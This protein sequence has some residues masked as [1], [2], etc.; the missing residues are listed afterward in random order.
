MS[1]HPNITMLPGTGDPNPGEEQNPKCCCG[2][3]PAL[4]PKDSPC[5]QQ[6]SALPHTK[7]AQVP[8]PLPTSRVSRPLKRFCC[9]LLHSLQR[10]HILSVAGPKTGQR[11]PDVGSPAPHRRRT[12]IPL[13]SRRG[14]G[15]CGVPVLPIPA[16]S[17]RS[18]STTP[19]LWLG[20]W[21][22]Q[23]PGL[24]PGTEKA[25]LCWEY[26]GC[27]DLSAANTSPWQ[28]A[29][30][31]PRSC[32]ATTWSQRPAQDAQAQPRQ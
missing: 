26:R 5:L 14:V 21:C 11:T 15:L 32:V 18:L 27:A 25:A 19:S 20:S 2:G 24:A 16:L 31:S 30:L 3:P 12:R 17:P 8:Q 28:R 1:A 9:P 23:S 6:Q 10:V 22:W 13:G 4:Q 7:P 29:Q